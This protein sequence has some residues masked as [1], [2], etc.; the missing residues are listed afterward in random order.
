[1]YRISNKIFEQIKIEVLSYKFLE[2]YDFNYDVIENFIFGNEFYKK[3]NTC[4]SEKNFNSKQVFEAFKSLI[5]E[6]NED[7]HVNGDNILEYIYHYALSKSFPETV[8]YET[9][10]ENYGV[11]ELALKLFHVIFRFENLCGCD[12]W[13]GRYPLNL[14]ERE[15]YRKYDSKEEYVNFIASFNNDY[16]YEMMKLNQ[17][18]IGYNTLDHICGVHHI[19]MSIARQLYLKGLEIDLGLVSGAASGHDIGK[20]GCK[21]EEANKVAY[22]HYYY[23]GEWFKKRNIVYIRNIAINH[24]TWDLELENLTIESLLLIYSDFRVKQGPNNEMKFYSL[25]ESF[26]VILNKLDNLDEV[27]TNRYR[28]VYS[29]LKD[30][31]EYLNNYEINL[32]PSFKLTDEV[33]MPR[34]RYYSLV[35]GQEIIEGTKYFSISH[36]IRLMNMIKT[37]NSS[38][39]SKGY[40]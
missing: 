35:Q 8:Q 17:D 12:T 14:L 18:V 9:I 3:I 20:F 7:P 5:V 15:E 37:E 23:S 24:S 26:E 27:K 28:R 4:V 33:K 36:N 21:P 32:D 10:E 25:D 16:I 22:Y 38:I 2:K 6:L 40:N 30:F 34:R 13:Q 11:M 31:E 39:D 19:S 1:M 29:K